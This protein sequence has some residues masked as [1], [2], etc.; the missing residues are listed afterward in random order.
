M[1]NFSQENKGAY[2]QHP[3][4]G[5]GNQPEAEKKLEAD[6]V[7]AIYQRV[8][9]LINQN[10]LVATDGLLSATDPDSLYFK[11]AD[12]LLS[13]HKLSPITEKISQNYSHKSLKIIEE[14]DE[15]LS[16]ILDLFKKRIMP[17]FSARD[18]NAMKK[19]HRQWEHYRMMVLVLEREHRSLVD[20]LEKLWLLTKYYNE[21][22]TLTMVDRIGDEDMRDR[23][24]L[25]NA[26][27]RAERKIT[28]NIDKVLS[29]LAPLNTE[30]FERA[31]F[32]GG[33]PKNPYWM[34]ELGNLGEKGTA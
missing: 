18:I 8:G 1:N 14:I 29:L 13:K 10:L 30:V 23:V 3:D 20:S 7:L 4:V 17:M 16:I 11:H 9:E 25:S 6:E 24:H 26:I 12:A 22:L 34:D 32:S 5:E 15:S 31:A 33:R 21:R 2:F 19:G 27:N 28:T